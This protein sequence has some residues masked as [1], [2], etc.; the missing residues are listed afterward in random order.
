VAVLVD[1]VIN[2]SP[3]EV[4]MACRSLYGLSVTVQWTSEN[5]VAI[6]HLVQGIFRYQQS[7]FYKKLR[8]EAHRVNSTTYYSRDIKL[9]DIVCSFLESMYEDLIA[10]CVTSSEQL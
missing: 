6:A 5:D 2:S 7:I 8:I 4:T 9:P 3:A 1:I 10:H